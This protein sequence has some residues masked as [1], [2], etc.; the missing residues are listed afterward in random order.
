LFYKRLKAILGVLRGRK[1]K[2]KEG[3]GKEREG[4]EKG[5]KFLSLFGS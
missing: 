2:V 5:E 1:R 3:E 4:R